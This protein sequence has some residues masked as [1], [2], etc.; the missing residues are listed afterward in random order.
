M[1]EPFT[2]L[3]FTLLFALTELSIIYEMYC[4]HVLLYIFPPSILIFNFSH[5]ISVRNKIC[6]NICPARYAGDKTCVYLPS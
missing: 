3:L 4:G 2:E 1:K 6:T 5:R